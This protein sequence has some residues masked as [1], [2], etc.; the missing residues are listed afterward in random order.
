M[1][2]LLKI[3]AYVV[4]ALV[5]VVGG[6]FAYISLVFDPNDYKAQIEQQVYEQ[7][8]RTLTINGDL[9]LS[10][11]PSLAVLI[12]DV[13]LQNAPGF[14]AEH[15]LT[16]KQAR[17]EVKVLPLLSK[18]VEIGVVSL[19]DVELNLEEN[20]SGNNWQ[21]K[22]ASKPAETSTTTK[23]TDGEDKHSPQG[24]GKKAQIKSLTVDGLQLN[25]LALNHSAP[26]STS[27][28]VVKKLAA[29][30]VGLDT[31]VPI[32][33]LLSL[34]SNGN[35]IELNLTK[36]V[37]VD[38][39][40]QNIDIKDAKL[41]GNIKTPAIS[42]PI[43]PE[44]TFAA[45][46]NL[47]DKVAAVENLKLLILGMKLNSQAQVSFADALNYSA[48]LNVADFELVEL[49]KKM[50][51]ALPPMKSPNALSRLGLDASVVGST[52]AVALTI[53]SLRVD[54][55][56]MS[57]KVN[58]NDI[59]NQVVRANLRGDAVNLDDYMPP[60]QPASAQT[61][62]AAPPASSSAAALEQVPVDQLRKAN[63]MAGLAF[64]KVIIYGL[65]LEEVTA[66]ASVVKGLAEVKP[67]VAK[68][69]G[70]SYQGHMAYDVRS[71]TPKVRVNE[72]LNKV[73]LQPVIKAFAGEDRLLG[74]GSVNVAINTQGK[75]IEDWQKALMGKGN[76]AFENG[77]LKGLNI[78]YEIR[79]VNATLKGEK[80]PKDDHQQTDFSSVTA[81]FVI[82]K[83]VL[84][85]NDL[86]MKSPLIRVTGKGKVNV[87]AQSMDYRL[88][89]GVVGSLE[90]QGGKELEDL[91][92]LKIPFRIK[93]PW[94][95]LKY[96]IELE[97]L[98]Q[99]QQK[100]RIEKSVEKKLE[101]KL[102]EDKL[103]DLNKLKNLFGK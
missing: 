49:L 23:S 76:I 100:K 10:F 45:K 1:K 39:Q 55:T 54:S 31:W 64:D 30:Q 16:L 102:G 63:A 72:Q 19:S 84:T 25:N 89:V 52:N 80:I 21:F 9:G 81:S 32:E 91:K 96:E 90:G 79:K 94:Q 3:L 2:K 92:G 18:Q 42:T 95:K 75:T 26:G 36:Q 98:I 62:K 85:S 61:G 58:V 34:S 28:V 12:E 6:V 74:T 69:Y 35:E 97:K 29:G 56:T 15:F 7:T 40:F 83:G 70:G 88:L 43:K 65:N 37:K 93:G 20:A 11:F 27:R 86:D 33:L 59:V 14:K 66:E 53:K 50:G 24:Q 46:V 103:K 73:Q 67:K 47:Q 38:A 51:V 44:L 78:P 5:V 8:G 4:V 99:D 82:D 17:A 60:A 22:Q 77:A 71:D 101:K 87:P 68:F 48:T 41:I 57:G 13:R